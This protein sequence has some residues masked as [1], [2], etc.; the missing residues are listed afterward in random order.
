M[1]TQ[2]RTL[3]FRG[4]VSG[5]GLERI[6]EV[7]NQLAEIYN[8]CL[9][10]YRMAEHRDPGLF[11]RFL[12][13]RQLT[14]LRAEMPEFSTVLRRMQETTVKQAHTSWMRYRNDPKAGRPRFKP[15]RY[16]TIAV[17]SPEDTPI[18]LSKRGNPRL[19]LKGLPAIRLRGSRKPPSDRQPVKISVTLKGRRLDV[20]LSYKHE[21][22]EMS[23]S[24]EPVNPLGVDL[25]LAL[26]MAT[27]GGDTYVSP[28]EDK[29]TGR[30][31]TA[32]RETSR[33]VAVA[34]ATGRAGMRAVLDD[35]NRQVM[36]ARG[37]PKSELI[38]T[39]GEPTR[40]YLKARRKLQGLH[41][42]RAGLK[43]DFRHR[44]TAQVVRQAVTDG[45][46]LIS[47]EDL[48]IASMTASARGST[49]QPG[50]NVRQKSGLNRRILREGWGEILAMLEYKAESAGI[51]TVRVNASG[52]NTTCSNCGHRDSRSRRSQSEFR[53]TSCGHR[54]NADHNASLNIAARGLARVRRR[55][56]T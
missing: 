32:Q 41:E 12:Q 24:R 43:R 35:K 28:N 16:R 6:Q 21:C 51:P 30:I 20:R 17:D 52:T 15:T 8:T 31:R 19:R 13:G 54:D 29:L 36:T 46:D 53:C 55:S 23:D 40:S 22:A 18:C 42:R 49:A 38:W 34:M 48:G 9:S 56:G 3:K 10:Q 7:L 25:G 39:D 4:Q 44:A 11:N 27:S 50:R 5:G 47:M 1:T 45:N 37:R 33:V 14:E 26:T 2:V